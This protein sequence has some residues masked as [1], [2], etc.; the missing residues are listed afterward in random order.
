[1]S[2]YR[3]ALHSHPTRSLRVVYLDHTARLSGGELALLR[4]LPSLTGVDAHV[5]LAEDGPLV[6]K[7]LRAGVSVEVL[8]LGDAARTLSRDRVRPGALAPASVVMSAGYTARLARRLRQLKPDLVHTNSLKAA[9]YG[10][11]A[12]RLASV[13]CIWHLRDRISS[14]YLPA[15]AANLVQALGRRL[16]EAVIADSASSL[17]CLSL[18]RNKGHVVASPVEL[19]LPVPRPDRDGGILRYGILGRIAQ[20]KGQDLFLSAFA[21]A[22]SQGKDRAVVV[23]DAM[24]E[25]DRAYAASLPGLAERLGVASRVE[26]RGF[27]ED[28]AHELARLDVLVHASVVPEPFGQVIV[29]GMAAGLAVVAP[30]AGGPAEIITNGVNGLLYRLGD[31]EALAHALR[32]LAADPAL[33]GRLGRAGATRA[34]DFAPSRVGPQVVAIYRQVLGLGPGDELVG[35]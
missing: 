27:T 8:P 33:R 25:G 1:L 4:L 20:W 11:L 7:L 19:T 18:D 22:F 15:T 35:R 21:A 23:G 10:G 30:D 9:I 28:V 31:P 24:F 5:I 26:L 13:P 6:G 29:E 32:R 3:R 12:A 17:A 14:D 34:A 16:P 2:V